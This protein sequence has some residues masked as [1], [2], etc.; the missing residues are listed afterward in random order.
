M[1]VAID[2]MG[3]DYA[4]A[5]AVKGILERF[6]SGSD[7]LHLL[8]LGDEAVL[9]PMLETAGI[10]ADF[11]TIIHCAEVIGYHDHPVKALKEKPDS[12][13][14]AGFGLLAKGK[15][16]AFISAGNTGAMLVG[17]MF[18]LKTIEGLL[19]PTIATIIPR[20]HGKTGLLL[21]VGIN[22]DCKPENLNQ[23]A[24]IGAAYAGIILG[25]DSPRVGLLNIGE[26]EGKGNLLAKE[27]FPLL[28]QNPNI[29]FIG[30]VEGRDI[31]EDVADVIVCDGFTGNIL[32]KLLESI[33]PI[34]K[35]QGIE[36]AYFERFHFEQYGGTPVLGVEKPVIIGH[37]V[38]GSEAFCN[39]INIAEKI[40]KTNFIEQLK[41]RM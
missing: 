7:G 31:L 23:F 4:P 20:E 13:I 6:K 27:A 15:A 25:V 3:G 28:K 5:E 19:R 30:N 36:H 33:Y 12:S 37:G 11:Y 41:A 34:T 39:M 14:A 9:I 10:P 32:L 26:E 29:N 22:S 40:I 21:D 1:T 17:S 2:M 38:S 16:D 18:S 24:A 8:L 35:R